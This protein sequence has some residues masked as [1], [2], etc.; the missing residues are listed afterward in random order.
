MAKL[1]TMGVVSVPGKFLI[2]LT[3]ESVMFLEI[4]L[5][6]VHGLELEIPRE[7]VEVLQGSKFEV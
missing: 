3:V 1:E 5:V 6:V 7:L 4:T 2:D